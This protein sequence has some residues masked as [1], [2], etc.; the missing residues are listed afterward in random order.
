M[1]LYQ[2]SAGVPGAPELSG[3]GEVSEVRGKWLDH[4]TTMSFNVSQPRERH[5]F[6]QDGFLPLR[7]SPKLKY[8]CQKSSQ[9][10]S[11][12]IP[13]GISEL[14]VTICS[15]VYP[16]L[17]LGPFLHLFSSSSYSRVQLGFGPWEDP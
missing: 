14:P 4:Y 2:S 10:C 13:K 6:K 11:S 15:T 1:C 5:A 8:V 17:C 9:S 12:F 3:H 16:L 7:Q